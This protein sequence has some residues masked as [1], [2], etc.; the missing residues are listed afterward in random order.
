MRLHFGVDGAPTHVATPPRQPMRAESA[1][2][3]PTPQSAVYHDEGAWSPIRSSR[4]HAARPATA[5]EPG[6]YR[7]R[8]LGLMSS[9]VSTLNR[10]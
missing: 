6:V 5:P 4:P 9:V 1:G 3:M 7:R 8:T 2:A 10:L